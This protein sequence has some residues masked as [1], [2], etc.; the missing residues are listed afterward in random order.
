MYYRLIDL[1]NFVVFSIVSCNPVLG[2]IDRASLG[3][4]WPARLVKP[5]R[6]SEGLCLRE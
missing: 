5:M 1:V 6:L 4:N 3:V 2:D